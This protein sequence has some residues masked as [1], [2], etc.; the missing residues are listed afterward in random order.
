MMTSAMTHN[1]ASL[2]T[3]NLE[4][5]LTITENLEDVLTTIKRYMIR[6]ETSYRYPLPEK[7]GI[8]GTQGQLLERVTPEKIALLHQR[9]PALLQQL[10][11]QYP[12]C[13]VKKITL[14]K[15]HKN[16]Y[17]V[18]D[19]SKRPTLVIHPDCM[20]EKITEE[21]ANDLSKRPTLVIQ[22]IE[23]KSTVKVKTD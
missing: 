14:Q 3:E 9:M 7:K 16:Q 21:H 12:D 15:E 1:L 18:I 19:W 23:S 10:Q 17:I 22:E 20:V 6:T 5:V 11:D 8:Y 13:L 2:L 4:D